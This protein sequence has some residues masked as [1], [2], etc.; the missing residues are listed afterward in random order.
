MGT[1]WQQKLE[2]Y[3]ADEPSQVATTSFGRF[4]DSIPLV[5]AAFPR[6]KLQRTAKYLIRSLWMPNVTAAWLNELFGTP[7][8]YKLVTKR[9]RLLFKVHRSY[10]TKTYQPL[11]RLSALRAHYG[12]LA[13]TNPLLL[14]SLVNAPSNTI[15]LSRLLSRHFPETDS[16]LLTLAI[17]DFADR[18]GE[19]LLTLVQENGHKRI[20]SLAFTI[21]KS[22][23]NHGEISIGCLQGAEQ[24]F[25]AV[26]M[27]QATQD[28]YRWRPKNVLLEA[29]YAM[30]DVWQIEHIRGVSN[31]TGVF[32]S[33]Q[34]GHQH[35][36]AD[37][38][39]FWTACGGALVDSGCYQLPAR[40]MHRTIDEVPSHHRSEFRKRTQLKAQVILD[41][42]RSLDHNVPA[43]E[44]T[45][46]EARKHVRPAI[47]KL[48]WQTAGLAVSI[49][50]ILTV[51]L[52]GWLSSP[53]DGEIDSMVEESEP[54]SLFLD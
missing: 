17:T 10:L 22:A 8:L 50:L 11:D 20:A 19:C 51:S 30:A 43:R 54:A 24:P 46:Q 16:Y 12:F 38:D 40:L 35:V 14:Q 32:N 36:F 1:V 15:T 39:A 2:Q 27:K 26:S 42:V 28:L 53:V 48:V 5:W 47:G 9:P 52:V 25:G 49:A 3:A 37:Y 13:T 6:H 18:E 41:I 44:S 7:L 45:F 33:D 31:R 4:L 34:R 29:V 21:T 23:V